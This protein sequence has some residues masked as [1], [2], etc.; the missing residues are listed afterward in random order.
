MSLTIVMIIEYASALHDEIPILLVHKSN[1]YYEN[2]IPNKQVPGYVE[3]IGS[4][5]K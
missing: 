3:A 2:D 4:H 5:K 1:N